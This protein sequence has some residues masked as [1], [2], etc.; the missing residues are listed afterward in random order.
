MVVVNLDPVHRQSG[1]IELPLEIFGIQQDH[2]YQLHDLIT[3][4]RYVWQGRR[5]Y[6]ELN[7]HICPAHIFRI[8]RRTH[9]ERDFEYYM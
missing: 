9:S 4:A 5:N 6:V 7:P 8:R 3:D 2:P 1:F